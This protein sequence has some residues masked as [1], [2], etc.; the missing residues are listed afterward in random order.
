MNFTFVVTNFCES[1]ADMQP[2]KPLV[3]FT[4]KHANCCLHGQFNNSWVSSSSL[5]LIQLICGDY[6]YLSTTT[7]TIIIIIK[8][9]S[10]KSQHCRCMNLHQPHCL[11][12][13]L[14]RIIP[15]NMD[16]FFLQ[17]SQGTE[18]RIQIIPPVIQYASRLWNSTI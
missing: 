14:S 15:T 3:S 8:G 17:Y 6:C 18:V 4:W 12:C 11:R 16:F 9:P 5:R 1:S 13:S 7:T 10:T 2:L